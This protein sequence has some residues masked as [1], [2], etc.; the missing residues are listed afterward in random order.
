MTDD[1]DFGR[2][3]V[4][5]GLLSKDDLRRA[6]NAQ[7]GRMGRLDTEII[8]LKLLSESATRDAL[9]KFKRSRTVTGAEL[10]YASPSA[11]RMLTPRIARLDHSTMAP[12]VQLRMTPPLT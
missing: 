1:H 10:E 3:L 5:Q 7:R 9:G 11:V 4:T 8:D 6:E 12:T 2:W